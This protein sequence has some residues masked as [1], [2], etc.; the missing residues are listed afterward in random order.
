M[1]KGCVKILAFLVGNRIFVTSGLWHGT[2]LCA[3]P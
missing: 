3:A 1:L 2:S